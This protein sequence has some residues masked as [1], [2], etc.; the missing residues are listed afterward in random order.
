[1][2]LAVG[3]RGP[4]RAPRGGAWLVLLA[5]ASCTPGSAAAPAGPAG[6]GAAAPTDVRLRDRLILGR[7]IG[8]WRW[9]H[10]TRDLHTRRTEREQ[11]WLV[12]AGDLV[13]GRY[14]REVEV[15]S[16]DGTPFRCN[17]DVRYLQ[18][19]L[20]D[21]VVEPSPAGPQ[22][23]ET[24]VRTEAS[25]CDHGFRRLGG[26]QAE[27]GTAL[28]RLRWPD[29]EAT[30][31]RVGPAPAALPD[32]RW[33]GDAPT[34]AGRWR[35]SARSRDGAHARD[36]AE[37]WDLRGDLM[38]GPIEGTVERVVTSRWPAGAAPRCAHGGVA[39][40][41][42]RVRVQGERAAGEVR[43]REVELLALSD[44]CPGPASGRVFEEAVL[45][46]LG[47]HLL[48]Q[49]RGARPQVLQRPPA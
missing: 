49:W 29:G 22:V 30:L 26:Y 47:D 48:L 7:L 9:V 45:E 23:R 19:A 33:P 40:R 13:V 37:A 35:W 6:A 28:T 32:P 15:A 42:E 46:Q 44:D 27:V 31:V 2:T 41:R 25:P 24:A 36:H 34:L 21:V 3:S 38:A 12:P 43:L 5:V 4:A 17:Q 16:V 14:L 1:V 11:W 39:V 8:T 10:Q 20:F 18:R